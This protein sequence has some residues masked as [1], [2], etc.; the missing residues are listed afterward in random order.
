MIIQF[1]I[2]DCII[3]VRLFSRYNK[4]GA[5]RFGKR[6][7]ECYLMAERPIYCPCDQFDLF[8]NSNYNIDPPDRQNYCKTQM[9][10]C[11]E[12]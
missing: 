2:H 4:D 6:C 3:F 9:F 5:R 11:I 1:V 7:P 10:Q 8:N 12:K